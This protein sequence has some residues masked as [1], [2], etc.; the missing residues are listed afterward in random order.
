MAFADPQTVT[1]SGT[2]RTLART[3]SGANTGGFTSSDGLT[4]LSASHSYGKRVRRVI[5]LDDSK[6]AAD[7][8]LA[9][10]NVK[11]Q[12]STYLVVDAPVTGY[13]VTEQKAEVDAFLAYLT[14][15]TGAQILKLLGGES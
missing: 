13:S 5:R 2:A 4:A 7:P 1:V 3:S 12:F 10:I 9:G 14:A 11:A 15:A 8:L 6:I